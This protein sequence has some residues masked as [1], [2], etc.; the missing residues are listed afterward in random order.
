MDGTEPMT[1]VATSQALQAYQYKIAHPRR[2]LEKLRRTL[3]K[4]ELQLMRQAS[5]GPT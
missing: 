4:K 5:A 2:E 3:D 1:T